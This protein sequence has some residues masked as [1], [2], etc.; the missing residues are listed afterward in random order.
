MIPGTERLHI[1]PL[2]S[3]LFPHNRSCELHVSLK[4][5]NQ[6]LSA[7]SVLLNSLYKISHGRFSL[8]FI[9]FFKFCD[10]QHSKSRNVLESVNPFRFSVLILRFE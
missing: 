8:K 5:V 9:K 7:L 4:G 6:I 3:S 2:S 10:N 1:I